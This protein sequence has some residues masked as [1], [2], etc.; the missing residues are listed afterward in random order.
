MWMIAIFVVFM[1]IVV[2]V[3]GNNESNRNNAARKTEREAHQSYMEQNNIT[4]SAEYTYQNIMNS[5]NVRYIVDK[6]NKKI[7]ISETSSH[8]MAIPFSEI[9]GCELLLVQPQLRSISNHILVFPKQ[10]SRLLR[11]NVVPRTRIT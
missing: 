2:V 7:Y 3:A 10:L 9:I 6:K 5:L 8:F 4:V 11:S 1:L